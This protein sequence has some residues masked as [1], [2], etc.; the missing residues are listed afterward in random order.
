MM[1]SEVS[2]KGWTSQLEKHDLSKGVFKFSLQYP[3]D[4]AALLRFADILSGFDPAKVKK[5]IFNVKAKDISPGEVGVIDI[6]ALEL[7]KL[8]CTLLIVTNEIN[9]AEALMHIRALRCSKTVVVVN[10]SRDAKGR[11]PIRERWERDD[12]TD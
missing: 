6:A 2:R 10:G 1:F 7:S 9:C 3:L 4:Y 11:F 12:S 5:V 8:G